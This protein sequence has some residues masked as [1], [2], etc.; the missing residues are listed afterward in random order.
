M[1]AGFFR[2]SKIK[3]SIL[4]LRTMT[5]IQRKEEIVYNLTTVRN[6]MQKILNEQ[7]REVCKHGYKT[8][9]ILI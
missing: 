7:Q 4:T 5:T 6:N 1:L 8:I 3:P 2:C 9:R